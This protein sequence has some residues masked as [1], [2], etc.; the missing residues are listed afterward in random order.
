MES[1][2]HFGVK[3]SKYIRLEIYK[4]L[5][6]KSIF[7]RMRMLCKNEITDINECTYLGDKHMR[8]NAVGGS[9]VNFTTLSQS[10]TAFTNEIT[11]IFCEVIQARIFASQLLE[12]LVDHP[13]HA[14][15]HLKINI[16][17]TDSLVLNDEVLIQTLLIL[18]RKM[19]IKYQANDITPTKT[20]KRSKASIRTHIDIIN[21]S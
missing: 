11:I 1:S 7:G 17:I 8:I 12:R 3:I 18:T 19:V 5:D 13:K 10:I 6:L 2:I 4:Y 20:Y 15:G 21:A 16:T 14:S 9:S